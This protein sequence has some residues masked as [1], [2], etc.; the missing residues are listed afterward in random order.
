MTA[1]QDS[2]TLL[3]K[4]I[5]GLECCSQNVRGFSPCKDCPYNDGAGIS[6]CVSTRPMLLDALSILKSWKLIKSSVHETAE[7]NAGEDGNKDVFSILKWLDRMMENQEHGWNQT[8]NRK[9]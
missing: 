5:S 8:Q 4:V 7:N 3:T 2:T 9:E 6:T 1:Q